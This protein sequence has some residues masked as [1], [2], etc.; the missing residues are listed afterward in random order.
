MLTVR[1]FIPH[2]WIAVVPG[3][4]NSMRK[5]LQFVLDSRLALEVS[6]VWRLVICRIGIQSIQQTKI[7]AD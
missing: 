2:D 3:G 1:G 4:S 6:Q 7:I 5:I